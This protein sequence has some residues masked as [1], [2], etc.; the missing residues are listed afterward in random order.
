M[1]KSDYS[2]VKELIT[3]NSN[4]PTNSPFDGDSVVFY[5]SAKDDSFQ[6]VL[7]RLTEPVASKG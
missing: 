2:E 4:C 5:G 3:T 1:D 6:K 7:T